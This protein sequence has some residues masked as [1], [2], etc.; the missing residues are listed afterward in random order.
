MFYKLFWIVR[1]I[2]YKPFFKQLKFPSY[3]G[4]PIF[5]M[6]VRNI[7]L[8]KRTRIFP[9]ARI[10]VHGKTAELVIE[11]N[12]GI[13]QSVHIIVGAK[14]VIGTGTVIAP[15]VFINDMDNDYQGIGKTVLEQ[16]EIIKETRIGKKCFIGY[17]VV[18]H[19]GTILGE[20]NIVGAGAVVKGTYPDYCVIVGNPARIIKRYD[21][22]SKVWKKTT[23]TGEFTC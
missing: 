8:G 17:G 22:L 12:V 13:G 1:A 10:E 2:L 14:L 15:Q 16:R 7:S 23:S 6:G 21:P 20:Q 3:I 5:L 11:E 19:A 4:K 9:M 18:I